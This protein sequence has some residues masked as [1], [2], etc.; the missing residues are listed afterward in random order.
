VA[1]GD[2]ECGLALLSGDAKVNDA[3]LDIFIGGMSGA[4]TPGD[5]KY[6]SKPPASR[7]IH[8]ASMHPPSSIPSLE[9]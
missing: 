5:P 1:A 8:R 3:D 4:N 7:P 9:K 2:P 6:G